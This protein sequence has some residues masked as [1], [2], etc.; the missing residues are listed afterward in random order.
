M[1]I[2]DRPI[3]TQ[4]SPLRTV[5]LNDKSEKPAS[6]ERSDI[7][8]VPACSVVIEMVTAF[9]ITKAFLEKFGNDCMED[10][11]AAYDNYIDRI[12]KY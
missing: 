11:K 7:C 10:I 12:S 8:A 5:D 2:R 4:Y 3:P 9:E 1:C 6:V